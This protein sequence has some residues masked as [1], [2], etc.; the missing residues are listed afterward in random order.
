MDTKSCVHTRFSAARHPAR[1]PLL[2]AESN[3]APASA[4]PHAHCIKHEVLHPCITVYQATKRIRALCRPNAHA[5]VR[6]P[7]QAPHHY[8][9]PYQPA[10]RRKSASTER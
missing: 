1:L 10:L 4:T 2:P 5:S 8:G 6:S 9:V 3:P 7:V